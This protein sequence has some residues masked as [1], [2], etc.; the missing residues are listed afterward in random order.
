MTDTIELDHVDQGESAG[1]APVLVLIHGLCCDHSDWAPQVAAFSKTHRVITPTL[2]GHGRSPRGE[3]DMTMPQLAS[4]VVQ[5]LRDKSVSQ[6]IVGGHSM[7]TRVAHEV[8]H[9]APEMVTGLVLVDGS[10]S[11]F[12]DFDTAM[13]GFEAASAGEKLKPWLRSLFEVMFFGDRFPDLKDACV[14]RALAMPDETVRDLYRGII[15]WDAAKSDAVMRETDVPTLVIQSTT[16]GEDGIRRP[17][18][19]GEM[20]HYP[21]IVKERIRSADF[22]LLPGHGHFTSLEAPEWTNDA[23]GTWMGKMVV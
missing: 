8:R 10:D 9:Q 2:R 6:A 14:K 5:L 4:D 22:A 12:G 17:L 18:N 16:R 23:I 1:D 3:A 20:G 13:A 21:G 7:G 15:A 11:A 19:E